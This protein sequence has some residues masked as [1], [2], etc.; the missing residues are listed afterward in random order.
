MNQYE[1]SAEIADEI[2]EIQKEIVREPV[3]GSV[4]MS[5]KVLTTYTGKMLHEH[6]LRQVERCMKLADKIYN[7]GNKLVKTAVE[8]V[9]VYSFSNLQGSCTRRE[10]QEIQTKMPVMLFSLYIQQIMK[11]G[12]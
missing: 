12:I 3:F 1:V 6:Q 8:N 9:F 11:P 10:W 5:I 2:P 7:K 4:Y